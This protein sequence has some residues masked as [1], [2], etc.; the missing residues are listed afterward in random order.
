MRPIILTAA[1]A[2]LALIPIA[3]GLLRFRKVLLTQS[4]RRNCSGPNPK[5]EL[6]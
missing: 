1:A 3:G 4:R 5:E 6:S 2:S